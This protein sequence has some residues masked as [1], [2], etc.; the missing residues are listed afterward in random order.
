MIRSPFAVL[1]AAIAICIPARAEI[2]TFVWHNGLVATQPYYSGQFTPA[3]NKSVNDDGLIAG[4]T[5]DASTFV[6]T[7][8]TWNGSTVTSLSPVPGFPEGV[9]SSINNH[10]TV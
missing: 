4:S 5:Q 8:A 7:A 6:R 1:C 9:A 3:T 2:V 10:G